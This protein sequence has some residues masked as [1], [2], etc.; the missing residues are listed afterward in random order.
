[1]NAFNFL[2]TQ[3]KQNV[4]KV[5][6]RAGTNYGWFRQMAHGHGKPSV[7]LAIALEE[8]SRHYAVVDTDVMTAA[9]ILGLESKLRER[10][11]TMSAEKKIARARARARAGWG[12]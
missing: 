3:T 1:M 2:K 10:I 9:E 11:L 12:K 5:C 7:D 6:E 8:A 4:T